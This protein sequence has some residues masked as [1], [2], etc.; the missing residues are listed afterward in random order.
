M[1]GAGATRPPAALGVRFLKA[2]HH[3]LPRDVALFPRIEA[4][5]LVR[6]GV[7][8]YVDLDAVRRDPIVK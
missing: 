6:Q 7:V 5:E 2:W 8:E 3:Y 1:N 4:I